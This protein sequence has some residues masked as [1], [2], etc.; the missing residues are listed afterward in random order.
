VYLLQRNRHNELCMISDE[1]L[2]TDIRCVAEVV[3]GTP[4]VTDYNEMG[5]HSY[6]TVRRRFGGWEDAIA[7]AGLDAETTPGNQEYSDEELLDDVRR[8]A[9]EV[10]AT[11]TETQYKQHGSHSP[12]T[13]RR[14]IGAWDEVIDAAGLPPR[15]QTPDEAFL[16]DLQNVAETLGHPP[17][18]AEQ[19]EQGS[20]TAWEI[21]G[22]FGTWTGALEEAGLP[23]D[24]IHYVEASDE[25]LV[26]DIRRVGQEIGETPTTTDYLERG[27]WSPAAVASHFGSWAAGLEAAGYDPLRDEAGR[28]SKDTLADDLERV[29]DEVGG[30]PAH[31]E[32]QEHGEHAVSTFQLRFGSWADALVETGVAPEDYSPRGAETEQLLDDLRRVARELGRSPTTTEYADRGNWTPPTL[33]IRFGSWDDTLSAAGL[34]PTGYKP[35][36]EDLLSDI[37]RVC[38]EV[39]HPP[40][41]D[42][43]REHGEYPYQA[44]ATRFGSWDG[45]L[46]DAGLRSGGDS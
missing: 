33:Y 8:V 6:D 4:G 45:A 11:P 17:S 31:G 19:N 26:E 9:E 41:R 43:Y 3:D 18:I 1:E 16:S 13:F 37:R 12:T 44:V 2:L 5:K 10:D 28:I 36:R 32:Y 15:E 35:P 46:L 7:E 22:R 25:E 14:R 30:V 21:R 23:S 38:D 20:F 40:S 34:G 29:A 39:G 27:H 42:E 24:G